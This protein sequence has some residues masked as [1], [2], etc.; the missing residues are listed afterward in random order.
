MYLH[1]EDCRLAQLVRFAAV[2]VYF[3]TG[4]KSSSHCFIETSII[5]PGANPTTSGYNASEKKMPAQIKAWRVFITKT[6][7]LWR[8]NALA[9]FNAGAV[10]VN[11][12]VV[13]LAPEKTRLTSVLIVSDCQAG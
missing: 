4:K 7:V 6:I 1:S 13:G 2:V 11:L 10:A 9:Y 8:K 12:K 5:Q 3:S